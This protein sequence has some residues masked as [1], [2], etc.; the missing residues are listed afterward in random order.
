V[1][2][3][4]FINCIVKAKKNNIFFKDKQTERKLY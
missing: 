2:T 4:R 3:L 1:I